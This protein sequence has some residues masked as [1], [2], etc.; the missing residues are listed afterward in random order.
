ME[1]VDDMVDGEI[2]PLDIRRGRSNPGF[3]GDSQDLA[4]PRF[5]SR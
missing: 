2:D 5:V 1:I 4:S 3:L